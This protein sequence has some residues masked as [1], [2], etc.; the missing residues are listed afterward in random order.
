MTDKWPHLR[1]IKNKIPEVDKN[2]DV[3][4]LIGCNCPK[5]MK[6][7]EVITGKSEDP[8]AV[9]TLLGWCI[10]GPTDLADQDNKYSDGEC[11]EGS[12]S[13]NRIVA[14]EMGR[15]DREITF[16]LNQKTTEDVIDP[17]A[18][19]RMMNLDFAERKDFSPT[20]LSK[21]DRQF[22]AIAEKGIHRAPDRHYELPLPFKNDKVSLPNIKALALHC[23][24]NLKRRFKK[25]QE[26][27]YRE[28]YVNFMNKLIDAGHAEV[29]P[30]ETNGRVSYIPHHGL[31]HRKKGKFCGVFNSAAQYQNQSLNS[32]LLQ[33][34]NLTSVLIR[35]RQ[36]FVAFTCDIEGMF[37][38]V[39]VNEEHRDIL[40]FLWWPDGDINQEPQ[41]YRMTVH[42]FGATSSFGC[43]NFALK[44][45][46]NDH[47]TEFGIEAANFLCDDFYV[48]DGLK[49][50]A[51]VEEAVALI[52]NAKKMCKSGG[53]NL[54]K[55]IS[56]HKD[57]IKSIQESDRGGVKELD[58][59]SGTLPLERTLGGQ[60]CIESD[61]F[62][63]SII[64]QDKPCTRRG[65]L[66]TVSSIFDPLG[67][68]SPLLLQG[69]FI[70]QDLCSRDPIPDDTRAKWE[71]WKSELLKLERIT[72]PRCYK[73]AEFG[74]VTRAELHHFSDASV[75]GY[76]QC[77]Y[78]RLVDEQQRVHC[79]FV[80]SK[81]RV[82]PL[83]PVT[84]PRLELTATVIS[85]RVRQQ[86]HKAIEYQIDQDYFWTDSKVVLG[87]INNETR[88][89]HVFV[90]NRVHEIQDNTSPSQWRY[91]ET[92]ENPADE[93]SRG[94]K[95]EELPDSCWIKGPEFL[96]DREGKWL[97]SDNQSHAFSIS[98]DDP[99][100]KKTVAMATVTNVQYPSIDERVE[101]FSD[102]K[103]ARQAVALCLIYFEKL[104]HKKARDNL[105]IQVED[106]ARAERA[107]ICWA[108]AQAFSEE[109]KYRK[110]QRTTLRARVRFTS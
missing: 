2:L 20:S 50:L 98:Q 82:A 38:Q 73:P 9:R 93:A 34:P 1:K 102:W 49:S 72:I 74:R 69:K 103:K 104:L 71:A 58:L 29:A 45:T 100:V 46:A 5:A 64:L 35:F 11:F 48:D 87:Y 12:G 31:Y 107:I 110:R 55:F 85:V 88:R 3:G 97:K 101:R 51:T 43:A 17:A 21:E 16:V 36:D 78:L 109:M 63:F 37:H 19:V 47:E 23:L 54:H 65:I 61:C 62:Q 86:I 70:L 83:K 77:S 84:V 106:L 76:G 81:S 95:A 30:K 39:T 10:V 22:L 66:S 80:M 94:V 79:S 90:S 40:R 25:P 7:R 99:E 52:K 8:Y 108:Q 92:K 56:N 75:K 33:G 13:C 28:D 44:A 24:Q 18:V 59:D 32:H 41:E 4:L 60:W 42:L 53:F 27:Q 68:V 67:F 6:P 57:V 15:E 14:R 26:K 96:W 105:Q 89:F 91:I